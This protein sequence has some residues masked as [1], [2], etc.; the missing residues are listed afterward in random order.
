ML[1]EPARYAQPDDFSS[2]TRSELV[3]RYADLVKMVATKIAY[4]LPPSVELDDL[5]SAGIIGLLD[6]I[7]KYDPSKSNNFKRYAEIRIRGAILDELRSLDWVSRSVRRQSSRLEG[8]N[9]RMAQELGRDPTE[10][11]M[12]KTLGVNIDQYHGL[13]NKLKPILVVSFEDLGLNQDSDRRSFEEFLRDPRAVD[14]YTQ[15][16]FTKL[17]DMLAGIV[18]QLPEKQR[19]VISLYYFD[20]MNLKEI[21]RVLNVTESRVSQLHSA[22]CKNLKGKLRRRT[23]EPGAP[24]AQSADESAAP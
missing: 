4:R 12:A 11:E 8:L 10:E 22:A 13:L 7:D 17:R 15:A 21:G 19:I 2:F 16:Y 5:I 23:R 24:E 6:A 9:K 14:P 18:S 3:E 1:M 20:E